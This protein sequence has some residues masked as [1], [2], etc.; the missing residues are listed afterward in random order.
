[1]QLKE[2]YICILKIFFIGNNTLKYFKFIR[3]DLATRNLLV[4]PKSV[5]QYEIKV[6]DFGLSRQLEKEF[7]QSSSKFPVKWS[8]PE[9]LEFRKFTTA[10]D[11]WCVFTF[12]SIL[13]FF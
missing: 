2:C 9:A 1:M 7:Y 6:S 3:R 11:V 5:D 13:K 10:A 4:F 12:H 8:A